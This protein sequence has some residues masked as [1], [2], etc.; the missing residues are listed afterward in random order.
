[1]QHSLVSSPNRTMKDKVIELKLKLQKQ[2][3]ELNDSELD[4][5]MY[6]L[7]RQGMIVEFLKELDN[8]VKPNG[9]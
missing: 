4:D 1:M 8:L 7:I 9:V 5:S 3:D 6:A 2:H